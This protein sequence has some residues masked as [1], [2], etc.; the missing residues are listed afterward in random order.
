M[1]YSRV[2]AIQDNLHGNLRNRFTESHLQNIRWGKVHWTDKPYIVIT[3]N[4]SHL[5]AGKLTILIYLVDS[6][7][8]EESEKSKITLKILITI[9]HRDPLSYLRFSWLVLLVTFTIEIFFATIPGELNH[10]V[11][12]LVCDQIWFHA[13]LQWF[14]LTLLRKLSRTVKDDLKGP[15]IS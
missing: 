11:M 8:Y 3:L 6:R 9:G 2:G 14:P 7:G 15:V 5:Q 1:V 12:A 13:L 10:S 4:R